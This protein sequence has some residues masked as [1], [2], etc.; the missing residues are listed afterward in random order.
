RP[1]QDPG[2]GAGGVPRDGGSRF[3]GGHRPSRL[4]GGRPLVPYLGAPA[5]QGAHR[6]GGRDRAGPPLR[7][8]WSGGKSFTSTQGSATMIQ[9]GIP[10][11]GRLHEPLVALL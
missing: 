1:S 6:C 9:V 3:R 2:E 11:K 5:P 4:R 10:S 8:F 7:G